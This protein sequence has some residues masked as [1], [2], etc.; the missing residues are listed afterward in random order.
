[1]RAEKIFLQKGLD[2]LH[3][4][5]YLVNAA[6]ERQRKEMIP[7]ARKTT[8]STEVK[9]RYNDRV[10]CKV[11]AELPRDT[12][13]AFKAKC[14]SKGISQASVLLEAIENFLRG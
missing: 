10:Y 2:I 13:T 5:C 3:R 6:G 14:K 9:R 8:T 12:V 11:Q 7:A 1:M 4:V